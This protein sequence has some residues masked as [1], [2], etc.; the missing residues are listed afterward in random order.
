MAREIHARRVG[1]LIEWAGGPVYRRTDRFVVAPL[2]L[3][4][5]AKGVALATR[6]GSMPSG[7]VS[8]TFRATLVQAGG[9]PSAPA[10]LRSEERRVGKECVSTCRSRWSPAH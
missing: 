3:H 6:K 1:P 7:A 5:G 4:R 8:P 9:F 2:P 10:A